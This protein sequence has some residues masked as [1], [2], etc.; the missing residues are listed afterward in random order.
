[1]ARGADQTGQTQPKRSGDFT[2]DGK[3]TK[4]TRVSRACDQCRASREKCDGSQPVCQSCVSQ[5]RECSYNEA[6]K[7]RGIQPNYIRTLE[8]ALEY[9]LEQFPDV[10]HNL[11]SDL[12]AQG[13]LHAIL[14]GKD[15]D[16]A[17]KLHQSWRSSLFGRQI[18]QV[19]SGADVE[20]PSL[21][22]ALPAEH[23]AE[24]S[25]DKP[26]A[27]EILVLRLPENAWILLDFY[28]AYV[29]AWM[30]MTEKTDMMKLLYAY[31]PDGIPFA[32]ATAAEHA[33]LW[34]IMALS[35]HLIGLHAN[36][37]DAEGLRVHYLA[38][39]LI[40]LGKTYEIPHLKAMI[41]LTLI[42]MS[43]GRTLDGW[44]RIGTVVRILR[45][46]TLLEENG[47]SR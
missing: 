5:D 25:A 33:E 32:E 34:S 29:H 37:D 21:R 8:L 28:F 30:P 15:V 10:R 20:H 36:Q 44:L 23:A 19:L 42:D 1:M 45:L 18:E 27:E 41:L 3:P 14:A 47:T 40:P 2:D 22:I 43:N 35:S 39:K 17:E 13:H 11:C 4:R 46:F 6:P 16:D 26:V 7:K 24:T 31:P 12:P 38:E 9:I